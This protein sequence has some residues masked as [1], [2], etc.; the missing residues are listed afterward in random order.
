MRL[1]QRVGWMLMGVVIGAV[2]GASVASG[3]PKHERPGPKRLQFVSADSYENHHF[4]FVRDPKS[5]ACWLLAKGTEGGANNVVSLA[6]APV[7]ACEL[8][9]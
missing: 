8:P 5:G 6:S 3:Q 4:V 7:N 1:T 2:T 9:R